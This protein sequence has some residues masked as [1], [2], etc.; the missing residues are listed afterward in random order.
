[1]RILRLSHAK[2][3]IN[4]RDGTVIFRNTE[5]VSPSPDILGELLV[6][7]LHGDESASSGQAF[8]LPL[9]FAEGLIR[10]SD[11]GS[12]KGKTEEVGVIRC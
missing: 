5:I 6:T 9:K 1:M 10:P 11:F 4:L 3:V 12:L 7:I 8:D 2:G